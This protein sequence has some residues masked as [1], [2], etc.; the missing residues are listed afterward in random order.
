MQ[1]SLNY[2]WSRPNSRHA[3]IAG[4]QTH[5]WQKQIMRS[6]CSRQYTE[7]KIKAVRINLFG[8]IYR[9]YMIPGIAFVFVMRRKKGKDDGEVGASFSAI[10]TQEACRYQTRGHY[11]NDLLKSNGML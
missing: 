4:N 2:A 10:V 7:N 11:L 8:G 3:L 5:H 9:L 6:K 1:K